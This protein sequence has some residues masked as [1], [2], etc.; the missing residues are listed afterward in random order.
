MFRLIEHFT[1]PTAKLLMIWRVR[2]RAADIH[3]CSVIDK[4]GWIRASL[5]A[6]ASADSH[7]LYG[8][9]TRLSK[10]TAG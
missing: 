6:S 7:T 2:R 8:G 4:S 1:Q 9:E 10:M 5:A 3:D